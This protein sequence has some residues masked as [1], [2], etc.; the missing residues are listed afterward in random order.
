LFLSFFFFFSFL[1]SFPYSIFQRKN[2][3]D[4]NNKH[5]IPPHQSHVREGS[6]LR[7]SK[8][9][10]ETKRELIKGRL[11]E[12]QE[13]R[14][15]VR[16]AGRQEVRREDRRGGWKKS[17]TELNWRLLSSAAHGKPSKLQRRKKRD[18]VEIIRVLFLILG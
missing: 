16:Q 6:K 5:P 9:T 8:S 2:L 4:D 13:L 1:F 14:Q 7:H 18:S 17:S 15:S 3:L 10:H 11:Q 12:K